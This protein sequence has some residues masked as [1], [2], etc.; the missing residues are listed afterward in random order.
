MRRSTLGRTAKLA[1]L[2]VGFAGRTALGVGRRVVGKPAQIVLT[3]V[4][5]RTADQLFRVLG[6]L[7]GGAMKLGQAMSIF[8]SALPDE[9]VGPYRETLTRLQ[10]AAPPMTMRILGTVL[11]E[12]L[13][14][15][16]RAEFSHFDEL[17]VASAS[18]GQVHRATWADGT[19]VAVKVQYPGAAKALRSDLKQLGRLALMFTALAP[20]ID[21]K[22]LLAEIE[23]RVNEELDYELEASAQRV[24]AAAF[25]GD[26]DFAVPHVVHATPRVL[27]TT[28]MDSEYSL[29]KV[30]REGTP[31]E[32]D[33]VGLLYARF[34][35]EGP[36]RTGLLHADPHPG[37]FRVL[38]DGRLGVVDYGAAARLPDGLPRPLGELLG[39]AAD[40]D[41]DTV[42]AGLR[43]EGFLLPHTR[44]DALALRDYLGPFLDATRV[45]EFTFSRRWLRGQAVRVATPT[46]QNIS[47]ALKLNLPPEYMLIHRVWVGGIGV[48]CQLETTLAFRA[49]L[50]E[51]VPGF[52]D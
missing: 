39:R 4:Q 21:I 50:E 15:G 27:V 28:W 41:W 42:A 1:T 2:P 45:E 24:F 31:E 43:R 12:E 32:R 34:L 17:P 10:D 47:N 22:P 18:I 44:F 36:A 30:I 49:L 8:E 38:A 33:R 11:T 51:N 9:L 46:Q 29:A 14:P 19:E 3:E 13:G 26:P 7:K 48:L 5:Q 40:G 16:W 23:A 52:A 20:G 37:N 6:E 25:D 35:F